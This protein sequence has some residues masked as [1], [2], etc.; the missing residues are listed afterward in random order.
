MLPANVQKIINRKGGLTSLDAQTLEDYRATLAKEQEET[1]PEEPAKAEV[2]EDTLETPV[3]TEDPVTPKENADNWEKRYG[4]ARR[5]IEDLNKKLK[6]ANQRAEQFA[7]GLEGSSTKY[8]TPEHLAKFD[9]EY[10]DMAPI[11][12]ELAL[13]EAKRLHQESESVKKAEEEA[14][15]AAAQSNDELKNAAKALVATAHPDFEEIGVSKVFKTWLEG[16]SEVIKNLAQSSEP[17]NVIFVLDTYKKDSGFAQK[18]V[19]ERKKQLTEEVKA[20]KEAI[21]PDSQP[22]IDLAK[23]TKDI[24][25]AMRDGKKQANLPKLLAQFD[26]LNKQLNNKGN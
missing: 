18:K 6:E 20:E 8:V 22:T 19:V 26:K 24:K 14:K 4:D 23:L 21:F 13:Q 12:R 16:Q 2:T 25:E 11:I 15:N 17:R 5:H 1:P 7:Q 10:G 9:E 3:P